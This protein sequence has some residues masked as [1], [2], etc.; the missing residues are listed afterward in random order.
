M[1]VA[2]KEPLAKEYLARAD[3]TE[4]PL[5]KSE[6]MAWCLR[7]GQRGRFQGVTERPAAATI[8]DP[9]GSKPKGNEEGSREGSGKTVQDA[10]R[11]GGESGTAPSHTAVIE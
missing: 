8:C 4:L 6:R 10:H 5:A 7:G 3:F 11:T 2:W 1:E 9:P